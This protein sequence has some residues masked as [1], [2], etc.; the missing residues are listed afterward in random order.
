MHPYS[1]TR[2]SF[3]STLIYR[4]FSFSFERLLGPWVDVARVLSPFVQL[5]Y[6]W[7]SRY[8]S[9]GNVITEFGGDTSK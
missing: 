6:L 9:G 8:L 2:K 4:I 5:P 1:G 7:C 3:Y